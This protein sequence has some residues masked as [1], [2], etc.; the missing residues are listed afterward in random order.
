MHGCVLNFIHLSATGVAEIAESTHLK[1]CA[2]TLYIW[3]MFKVPKQVQLTK[4]DTKQYQQ[5]PIPNEL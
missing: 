2:H 3:C 5:K 4:E 1:G